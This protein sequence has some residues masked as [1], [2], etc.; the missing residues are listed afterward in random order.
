MQNKVSRKEK[1]INDNSVQLM[2]QIMSKIKTSNI[3]IEKCA[4]EN[5]YCDT[6][7]RQSFLIDKITDSM[8][9]YIYLKDSPENIAKSRES[10]YDIINDCL[11][12]SKVLFSGKNI[13]VKIE[14]DYI[15]QY[16]FVN[17]EMIVN[18]ILKIFSHIFL[19]AYI[20]SKIYIKTN[21]IDYQ[22]DL[23][24][25]FSEKEKVGKNLEINIIFKGEGVPNDVRDLLFKK[26]IIK[27]HKS[28]TNNL[29][30]YTAAKIIEKHS[31][32]IWSKK[33]EEGES[34]IIL[35]PLEYEA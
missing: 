12:K 9:D 7:L 26:P 33:T 11:E 6:I 35:L 32:K 21:L 29:Y 5:K 8:N 16:L 30:L 4:K 28:Y 34:I 15:Y 3:V 17:R 13:K 22:D 1:K 19:T 2:L 24:I 31:G 27:Y 14:D 20:N 23:D 10:I 25:F 18:A